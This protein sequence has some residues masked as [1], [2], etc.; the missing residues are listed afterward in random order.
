MKATS[1]QPIRANGVL[2]VS[3]QSPPRM[4]L[5]LQ[6]ISRLAGVVV[7]LASLAATASV[8]PNPFGD[9]P[10]RNVFNLQPPTPPKTHVEEPKPRKPLPKISVTGLVEFR[11][12]PK[13]VLEITE[14]GRPVRHAILAVGG[15][16]DVL[17]ILAIDVVRENIRVRLNGT[18]EILAIE[19]PKPPT[20]LPPAPPR[21][22]LP[23]P[24]PPGRPATPLRG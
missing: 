17:E 19:K 14:P 24:L 18:E 6:P 15:A 9:I 1:A 2:P 22:P 12:G 16:V 11:A 21:P 4:K 5:R 3:T 8:K 10:K 23:L 7:A 20:G 13:A